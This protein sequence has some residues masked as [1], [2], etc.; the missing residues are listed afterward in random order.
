MTDDPRARLLDAAGRAF[1]EKG[2]QK[3]TVR[4][5]CQAADVNLASVNYYFG[6]KE[7]LYVEAVKRA[8][9]CHS[10]EIPE[11]DWDSIPAADERLGAFVLMT[12]RRMMARSM[13]PWQSRLMMREMVQPTRAV[14]ELVEDHFRPHLERLIGILSELA[15]GELPLPRLR[16]LGFSVIGQCLFYRKGDEVVRMIVP[17]EERQ[18]H[19]QAAP[20]AAHITELTLAALGAGPPL[21]ETRPP[22]NVAEREHE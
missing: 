13:E 6:D 5:I 19:F 10:T 22:M 1:A 18:S 14:R 9:L 17:E 12:V 16:Q 8:H 21:V 20:L 4:E 11:P 7:Q 15:G 2:Y 3:T